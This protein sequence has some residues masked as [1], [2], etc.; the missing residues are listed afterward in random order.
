[1]GRACL[2]LAGAAPP[3]E[4]STAALVGSAVALTGLAAVMFY[5][6]HSAGYVANRGRSVVLD[7]DEEEVR[8]K[9]PLP[10]DC[11]TIRKRRRSSTEIRPTRR[12]PRR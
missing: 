1:M 7:E 10:C 5:A 4:P 9:P 11:E 2:S 3:Q 6:M 12:W 8:E